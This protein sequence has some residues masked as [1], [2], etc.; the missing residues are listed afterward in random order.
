M[1]R[2][3]KRNLALV[4]GLPVAVALLASA[5]AFEVRPGGPSAQVWQGGGANEQVLREPTPLPPPPPPEMPHP[6]IQRDLVLDSM[7]VDIEISG[8]VAKTSIRQTLRNAGSRAAEGKYFMPLPKGA[9]VS[10]FAIIDGDTRLEPKV[11]DS[12]EARRTYEEIVRTMRD[13]GLLEYAGD[14]C[15]S[16]GVFPFQPGASRTVEVSFSQALGGTTEALS[17]ALPLRWAAWS[18][19]GDYG[20]G[21]AFTLTYKIDS[22]FPLGAIS[23]P[24][25]GLSVNRDGDNRASGSYEGKLTAIGSDFSLNIGRRT[26]EFGATLMCYPGEKGE[27]GYFIL[28][29]LAALPRD[30]KPVAKNS[31]FIFDKSGSMD[32]QKIEQAKGA[33]KFVLGRLNPADRFNLIYYSDNVTEHFPQLVEA[34][35]GN[36]GN[37]QG[38]ASALTADGGTDINT[39]L[40]SASAMFMSG[41][42]N[43]DHRPDYAIFLTDGLPTVG[44]TDVTRIIKNAKDGFGPDVKLFVFGVGYDVNTTLLDSLALDHHGTATYVTESENLETKVSEFYSKMASPA[45]TNITIDLGGFDEYDVMPRELPDLFHN[46]ELFIT[47]RY[48]GNAPDSVSVNVGGQGAGGKAASFSAKVSSS[49]SH[50]NNQIPRLW[51][52]RKVSYL[53]DQVRLK[54][55]NSELLKE[56]DRLALR[57][58]IVTPYT[59]YLITEPQQVW[60]AEE[61]LGA[62]NDLMAEAKDDESGQQAVGRSKQGQA[63]QTASNAAAP[64]SAGAAAGGGYADG[65]EKEYRAAPVDQGEYDKQRRQGSADPGAVVNYIHEQTFLRSELPDGR[66]QWVDARNADTKAQNARR[67]KLQTYSAEYFELLDAHP[68]LAAYLSQ[69]ENVVLQLSDDLVL[70]TTSEETAASG[71]DLKALESALASAG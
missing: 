31:V 47:G 9:S 60:R 16:V 19:L 37:A 66:V 61:R 45:L 34:S 22:Q 58:G 70:E 25:F 38:A 52:A 42:E 67:V 12:K 26:G 53:I 20:S 48:R 36:I 8:A 4:I 14:S 57:F 59:S 28:G 21:S 13:P 10:G 64:Q 69:G 6:V 17:Y 63:N 32:G 49:E 62:L 39:A 68:E 29:L 51:A 5:A 3:R 50:A 1:R 55:E 15:I 40:G 27:D 11:L 23:S 18:S 65:F 41:P 44:E 35:S 46:T 33:L 56:I 54:G 24:N 30:E 43:S 71:D 2:I 7:R